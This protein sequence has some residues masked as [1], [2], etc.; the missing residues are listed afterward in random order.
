MK[1]V[2]A[3]L[4]VMRDMISLFSGAQLEGSFGR[5]KESAH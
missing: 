4:R 5:Q 2:S 1:G 3:L